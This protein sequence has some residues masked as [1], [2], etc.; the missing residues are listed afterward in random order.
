MEVQMATALTA[1]RASS[2]GLV[3]VLREP[4]GSDSG[5]LLDAPVE[6]LVFNP[7]NPVERVEVGEAFDELVASIK[8]VGVLEPLV[9]CSA[10]A[11]GES[12]PGEPVSAGA[13]WVALAG[14][15]RLAAAR[16]AGVASVPAVVRD[17]L[18]GRDTEVLAH[19]NSPRLQLTA[20]EDARVYERLIAQG[21]TQAKIAAE[22]G[23]SQ[24][25]IARR[26][27]LLRLP[28][29][30]L[31]L[32]QSGSLAPSLAYD[33]VDDDH[34]VLREAVVLFG[35]PKGPARG[36]WHES[37][38]RARS[39][40]RL[41]AEL[42]RSRALADRVGIPFVETAD[43]LER[44]LKVSDTWNRRV[45]DPAAIK[46]GK[47]DGTLVAAPDRRGGIDYYSTVVKPKSSGADSVERRESD[48]ARKARWPFV[49]A[50]AAWKPSAKVYTEVLT[51]SAVWQWDLRW[52]SRKMTRK[53][54]DEFGTPSLNQLWPRS[55]GDWSLTDPP[56]A[57]LAQTAWSLLVCALELRV[58][59]VDEEDDD[60]SVPLYYGLL[61]EV[62]HTPTEWERRRHGLGVGE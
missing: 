34:D 43:D 25:H 19:E 36:R 27:A 31:G 53:L 33:T 1:R 55:D 12:W 58:R 47:K 41:R 42:A 22:M 40:F 50:L 35:D 2:T 51:L 18:A 44:A 26:L 15:R 21:M 60:P 62:G 45:S 8:A 23:R 3:S 54:R 38:S 13:R 10:A 57:D 11:W 7:H 52:G 28:G 16:A 39:E 6:G 29:E 56:E 17:D 14:N 48:V 37:V 61:R 24:G 59:S 20:V 9:V 4:G 5:S 49:G 32:I 30:V 46:A